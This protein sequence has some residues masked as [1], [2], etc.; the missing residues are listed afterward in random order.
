M[1]EVAFDEDDAVGF[2]GGDFAVLFPDAAV[3]GVLLLLEAVFVVAGL[4][5]VA[6][7][8][9][10]GA[11]EARL[12]SE[13]R[14]RRVRSGC[15]LPQTRRCRSST[16][17]GA[18]FAAAALVGLGGVG[19]AVAED[20]FAGVEGGLNDFGD[21]L[22]A[23][24]EHEGHL[25]H[26]SE[27]GGAGVEQDRADAVAGGGSAGLAGD[28]GAGG[29]ASQARRQTLDLGGFAGTVQAFESDE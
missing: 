20:D 17:C 21:G 27:G 16:S 3:E 29:R 13:G 9:A 5:F 14:S 28:D 7:V 1:V 23:V 25:G 24:G 10:A 18:E 26:G 22:G 15:R 2:A 19:E 6:G 12:R 4:G 11:G 8:A